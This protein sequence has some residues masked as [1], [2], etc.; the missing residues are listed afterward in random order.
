M[1]VERTFSGADWEDQAGYCR[2][3]RAG[4]RIHVSG[5]A[6]VAA[7][8][9]VA[10]PDDPAGQARRCWAIVEQALDELGGDL[11]DVVRTRMYVSDPDVW[12]P[13]AEVHGER[14]GDHPPATTLVIVDRLVD[15]GFLVEVEAEALVG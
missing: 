15:P 12:E 13:I 6:P 11:S 10:S 8:G 3:I 5:T 14:F 1:Q 2:A 9:G 4:D 7:D